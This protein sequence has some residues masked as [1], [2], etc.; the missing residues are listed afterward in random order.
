MK[1]TEHPAVAQN[2]SVMY[3]AVS[4]LIDDAAYNHMTSQ[5]HCIQGILRIQD[6]HRIQDV[7]VC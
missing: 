1:K 2:I 6:I 4:S 5:H 3:S 7:Q